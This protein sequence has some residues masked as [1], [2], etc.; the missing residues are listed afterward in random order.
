[1]PFGGILEDQG[2]H[3]VPGTVILNEEA[4]N[5]EFQ[6]SG[7][8][9]AKGR[10]NALVLVPQPSNDPNDPLNWP[11]FKRIAVFSIISFGT[12]LTAA[13]FGPLLNAGVVVL[14]TEFDV[15]ITAITKLIGDQFIVPAATGVLV[16]AVSRKLG[17]V[18]S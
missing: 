14:A 5:V 6:A 9:H 15:S 13:V 2:A 11:I 1:M 16:C 3:R 18:C 4:A 10:N 7:L 8:K 17:S 12:I